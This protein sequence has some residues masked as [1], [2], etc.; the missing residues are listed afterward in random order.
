MGSTY[1]EQ[2]TK[3]L[4]DWVDERF[5]TRQQLSDFAKFNLYLVNLAEAD[6]WV[7]DGHSLT[8]GLPWS[9]LVVRGTVDGI[10]SVVFT[11][12]QTTADCVRIFMRKM[13]GKLLEWSKDRFRS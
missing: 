8:I 13:E 6:G 2:F 9:R 1:L 5:I 4:E 10:P 12:G 3:S 11:S 7:Y